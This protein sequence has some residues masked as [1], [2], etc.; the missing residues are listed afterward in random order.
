MSSDPRAWAR[1]LCGLALA[2]FAVGAAAQSASA[3]PVFAQRYHMTCG[4]C[5]TALPELNAFG[6]AFR[7]RGYRLPDAVPRHGTTGVA[8]RYN[9]EY[10]NSPVPGARRFSPGESDSVL[11]DEDIGRVNVYLHYGLG[12]QGSP[13]NFYLGFLST[14]DA[15]TKELYRLGLFEMP[16]TQSPGQRLDSISEYGYFGTAVG[17]ND[18]ALNAPRVGFETERTIGNAMLIGTLA[19]GEYKGAAYGGAPVFTGVE[20][21]AERPEIGLFGR[22]PITPDIQLNAQ[23][24]DG[25][26]NIS[27]PGQHTFADSYERAG[28]GADFLFFKKTLDLTAQQWLGRDNAPDGADSAT[29]SSGGYLRLKYFLTPHL[30]VATRLDEAANP[31]PSREL[32]Q[33][34]GALVF[35][36]ARVVV[37]R[38]V[39]LLGGTPTFGG[40][41]TVAAPWPFGY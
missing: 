27:L 24:L 22:L 5:H 39:N 8:F 17:H 35:K 31:F 25:A 28:F 34:V 10:E 26:R 7:N 3:M 33:Y 9:F 30:F 11:A 21:T 2:L 14:Y 20:T 19:F 40:Y 13:S 32:L 36:H 37:E 18:L 6:N 38:R 4:A 1:T 16:L 23:I 41:V 29:D 15:H 12:S